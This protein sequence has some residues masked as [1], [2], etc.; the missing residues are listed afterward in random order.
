VPNWKFRFALVY[1]CAYNLGMIYQWDDEKAD[2]N[3]R[4]H[5]IEF[6]DA[7]SVFADDYAVTIEDDYPDEER[8]V[9]IGTDAFGRVL[10][11]V[12]TWRGE[13]IRVISARKATPQEQKQYEG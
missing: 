4:K 1:S 7:V 8:F 6:A 12:F 10:V 2:S 11:V 5:G 13:S 3:Y 9:I